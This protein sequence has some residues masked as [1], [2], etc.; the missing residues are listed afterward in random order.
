MGIGIHLTISWIIFW[1]LPRNCR[2]LNHCTVRPQDSMGKQAV[3]E[4]RACEVFYS[5]STTFKNGGLFPFFQGWIWEELERAMNTA[6]AILVKAS[7]NSE[8]SLDW[9]SSRH[10]IPKRFGTIADAIRCLASPKDAAIAVTVLLP[11]I[12]PNVDWYL[13]CLQDQSNVYHHEETPKLQ[14]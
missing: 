7:R 2:D 11:V 12:M 8:E 4:D 3:L 9:G 5:V 14:S 10:I 13:D 1:L 6:I